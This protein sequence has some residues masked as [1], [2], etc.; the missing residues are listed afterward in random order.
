MKL[1]WNYLWLTS[2]IMYWK[3]CLNQNFSL[4]RLHSSF[5]RLVLTYMCKT[6]LTTIGNR[7]KN[8]LFWKKITW[9]DIWTPE[10]NLSVQKEN[11]WKSVSNVFGINAYL[12]INRI[13]WTGHVWRPTRILKKIFVGKVNRKKPRGCIRQL[14]EERWSK[15]VYSR[16]ERIT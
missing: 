11:Q 16:R 6:R 4:V 10:R 15:Q 12:I 14:W 3:N 9:K 13:K 5:L 7:E 1:N 2:V 8:G